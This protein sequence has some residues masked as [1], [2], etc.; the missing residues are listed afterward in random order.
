MK[1]I[2]DPT[3]ALDRGLTAIRSQYKVPGDFPPAVLAAAEEASRRPVN[4]HVDRTA[5][6]FVTL[7]PASSTDLDQAFAIERCPY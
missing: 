7:D 6:P 4:D 5:M 2:V 1:T 3:H